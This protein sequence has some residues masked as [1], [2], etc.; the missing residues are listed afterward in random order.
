ME[1]FRRMK[2]YKDKLPAWYM[3]QLKSVEKLEGASLWHIQY[4][5]NKT[6]ALVKMQTQI[7]KIQELRARD[8]D[9]FWVVTRIGWLRGGRRRSKRGK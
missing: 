8:R 6:G 3:F 7:I 1:E 5:I 4:W 2:L 9:K